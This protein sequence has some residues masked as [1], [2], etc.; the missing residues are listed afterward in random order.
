MKKL[1]CGLVKRGEQKSQKKTKKRKQGTLFKFTMLKLF[2]RFH[3]KRIYWSRHCS[4]KGRKR[5]CL[6]GKFFMLEYGSTFTPTLFTHPQERRE[7]S[8]MISALFS[9]KKSLL[10]FKV[11]VVLNCR[12]YLNRLV[13]SFICMTEINVINNFCRKTSFS[14]SLLP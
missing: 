3:C 11:R 7:E 12:N 10:F 14:A 9:S 8:N 5:K 1:P 4:S 2:L 6:N 13:T